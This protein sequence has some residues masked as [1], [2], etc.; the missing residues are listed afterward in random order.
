MRFCLSMG[1][2]RHVE[3]SGDRVSMSSVSSLWLLH[4][5]EIQKAGRKARRLAGRGGHSSCHSKGSSGD[6]E[7]LA[8]DWCGVFKLELS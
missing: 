1:L 6:L 5:R 2:G 7:T 3:R 4:G 8:L